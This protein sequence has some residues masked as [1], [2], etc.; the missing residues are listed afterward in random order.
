MVRHDQA[1][2]KIQPISS[3]LLLRIDSILLHQV[4]SSDASVKT[5]HISAVSGVAAPLAHAFG[6]QRHASSTSGRWR[7]CSRTRKVACAAF[8]PCLMTSVICQSESQPRRPSWPCTQICERFLRF[9]IAVPWGTHAG[10]R[11]CLSPSES[12]CQILIIE[13]VCAERA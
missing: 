4:I 6:L 2:L 5:R 9:A 10:S 1:S 12:R 8:G 13:S 7:L 3:R 11:K